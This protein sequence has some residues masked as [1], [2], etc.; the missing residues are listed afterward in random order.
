MITQVGTTGHTTL[1]VLL[2]G[3]GIYFAMDFVTEFILFW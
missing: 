3:L 2:F 1:H